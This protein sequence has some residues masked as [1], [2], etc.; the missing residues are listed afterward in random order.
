MIKSVFVALA[1]MVLTVAT[2]GA[3][4]LC[5]DEAAS[6]YGINAN[7]LR[8]IAKVESNFNPRAVNWNRNGSYDFGIMQINSLWGYALGSEWWSTLGD[9]CTNIKAGA[10]ILAT[11]MKSY[12]YTWEAVGC[13]NSRTPARRDRYALAIFSQLQRLE[14]EEQEKSA[15]AVAARPEV[16]A[17]ARSD[18]GGKQQM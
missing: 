14:R 12:G 11:C 2:A 1:L 13:Y 15:A 3:G 16:A 8:A 17:E 9:P 7:I 18:S 6:Q 10:M 5:F 4:D